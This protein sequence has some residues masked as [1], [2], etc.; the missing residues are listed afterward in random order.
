MLKRMMKNNKQ[1]QKMKQQKNTV[2]GE[3]YVSRR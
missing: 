2:Y 1:K 3:D